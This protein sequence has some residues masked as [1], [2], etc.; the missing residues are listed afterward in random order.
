[1]GIPS[2][3]QVIFVATP[4]QLSCKQCFLHLWSIA[5]SL[6]HLSGTKVIAAIES[7]FRDA[8]RLGIEFRY[9]D[10]TPFIIPETAELFPVKN[11]AGERWITDFREVNATGTGPCRHSPLFERLQ[12]IELLLQ[13][14]VAKYRRGPD[15]P[16]CSFSHMPL[17]W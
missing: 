10:G 3:T 9:P 5:V 12:C 15:T 13:C 8:E 11:R 1:M 4:E 14:T 7:L 17:G 16:R 6:T 2:R